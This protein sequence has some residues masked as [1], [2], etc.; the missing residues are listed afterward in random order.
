[1]SIISHSANHEVNKY[2]K[3]EKFNEEFDK[4]VLYYENENINKIGNNTSDK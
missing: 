2:L 3:L 4:Q 1:M